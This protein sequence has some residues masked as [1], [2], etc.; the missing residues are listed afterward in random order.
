MKKVFI[1][2]LAVCICL[3][4]AACGEKEEP[5]PVVRIGVF[6]PFSGTDGAMGMKETLGIQYAHHLQPTVKVNGQTYDVELVYADNASSKSQAAQVAESLL[7][8]DVVLV[9]GSYGS[10]YS[11]AAA[12]VF[13]GAGVAA[14]GIS[15]TAPSI[16]NDFD[17]YY[18]VCIQDTHQGAALANFA[19]TEIGATKVLCLS[20]IGNEYAQ[21]LAA[22]FKS[23]A[24]Q[25]DID[26]VK[27]DFSENCNDFTPY[28]QS[29]AEQGIDAVFAPCSVRYGKLI[30]EAMGALEDAVPVFGGDTW[31]SDSIRDSAI[32][33]NFRIYTSTFYAEGGSTSFE[34]GFKEW[35]AGN[36]NA[37]ASNGGDDSVSA[38]TVMGYDAY[39]VALAAISKAG[40][41]HHADI[42]AVM[43]N[44]GSSGVSGIIN[45]DDNGDAIRNSIYI[46]RADTE[47]PLWKYVKNQRIG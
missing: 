30:V 33:K 35:L 23:T 42:L 3:S 5:N 43:P 36:E 8:E 14:L 24:A 40:S 28:L 7:A 31:D 16:T 4:M 9:L 2:L 20:Q 34:N 29:I 19:H 38:V 12:P 25:F 17:C 27:V 47:V 15:C 22:G 46:K 13:E 41:V 45:F 6:E 39:N 21:G 32:G 37:L 10:E 26:V 18:R 11:L 1:I 44:V